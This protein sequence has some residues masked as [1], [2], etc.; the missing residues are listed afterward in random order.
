MII[1]KFKIVAMT[2]TL[3]FCL[4]VNAMSNTGCECSQTAEVCS[5]SSNTKSPSWWNWIMGSKNGSQFHFFD[6]IEL[7]HTDD[8]IETTKREPK[9]EDDNQSEA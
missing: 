5:P 2:I 4:K 1:S 3:V 9:N 7:L 8:K 6:L